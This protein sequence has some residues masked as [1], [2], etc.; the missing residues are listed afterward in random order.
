MRVTAP[1]PRR[2]SR[3]AVNRRAVRGR[4]VA[5][6]ILRKRPCGTTVSLLASDGWEGLVRLGDGDLLRRVNA[7]A[8]MF[9]TFGPKMKRLP[10]ICEMTPDEIAEVRLFRRSGHARSGAT[11]SRPVSSARSSGVAHRPRWG[12]S[13]AATA[14]SSGRGR[15]RLARARGQGQRGRRRRGRRRSR[16]GRVILDAR[17]R[18]APVRCCSCACR[19]P[20]TEGT[21]EGGGRR[22]YVRATCSRNGRSSQD[23]ASSCRDRSDRDGLLARRRRR[24]FYR[25]SVVSEWREG[26]TTLVRE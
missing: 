24:A 25:V 18:R 3:G 14:A 11:S 26:A 19:K 10:V 17:R 12:R 23:V 1:R 7:A 9:F 6:T 4:R 16:R 13:S 22:T 20:E 15:P 21:A 5:S 8:L 2:P